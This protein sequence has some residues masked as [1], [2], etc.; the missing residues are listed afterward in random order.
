[1]ISKNDLDKVLV[2]VNRVFALL[3]ARIEKLENTPK[4]VCPTKTITKKAPVKKAPNKA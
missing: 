2:D 3:E 4:H 1:M